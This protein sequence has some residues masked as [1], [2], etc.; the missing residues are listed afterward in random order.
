[1]FLQVKNITSRHKIR[2][3]YF[4]K[5]SFTSPSNLTQDTT[6]ECNLWT[7]SYPIRDLGSESQPRSKTRLSILTNDMNPNVD[8]TKDICIT[9][10]LQLN[11]QLQPRIRS[12]TL[13]WDLTPDSKLR[14]NV[15]PSIQK[16]RNS[17]FP[18][19]G[20]NTDGASNKFLVGSRFTCWSVVGKTKDWL[21]C[22]V[23][24]LFDGPPGRPVDLSTSCR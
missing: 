6:L 21:K 11:S 24:L 1:M 4:L 8:Y 23:L 9:Q 20:A 16:I 13:T 17:I 14:P 5:Y 2:K 19:L 15:T 22:L 7:N 10:L 12:I 18:K 3:K